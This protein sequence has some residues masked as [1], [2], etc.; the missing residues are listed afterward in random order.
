MSGSL[1]K[2]AIGAGGIY[3]SYLLLS[4]IAERLFPY[5]YSGMQS[6]TPPSSIQ[7]KAISSSIQGCLFGSPASFV[8]LQV[9]YDPN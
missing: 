3:I 6:S 8:P 5:S 4:I 9:M 2:L 7:K 1:K